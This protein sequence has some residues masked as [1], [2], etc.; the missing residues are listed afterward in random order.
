[1]SSINSLFTTVLFTPLEQFDDVRWVAS[2]VVERAEPYALFLLEPEFT[3]SSVSDRYANPLSTATTVATSR[4]SPRAGGSLLLVA[5]LAI[6][7]APRFI[8]ANTVVAA[9][10]GF[11]FLFF[12]ATLHILTG[13]IATVW[14][15]D[16]FYVVSGVAETSGE[17]TTTFRFAPQFDLSL[18]ID[19]TRVSL[20]L[21]FFLLGSGEEEDDEDFLLTESADL[22]L[23]EEIIAPLILSN[24]GVRIQENGAL[25]LKVC[26]LFGFVLANNLRGRLP[27]SDTATSSLG[28]T[29]WTALAVFASL[30]TLRIQS[31]GISYFFSLFRPA[32]CPFPLLFLLIPIEFISYSFR[33]VSLAV[34]LFA[35]RRA[36]HTLRKVLIGFSY[37]FLTLGDIYAV[38]ALL[39][40]LVVF[41]LVFLER[42][43]AVIQAYIFAVL[44]CL[45]L[46]DIYVGHLPN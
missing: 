12:L 5:L 15:S 9:F 4:L 14:F 29:F 21:G 46:K 35:N 11:S 24:L 42:G 37:V 7:V 32:G 6:F 34:R 16:L 3:P 17:I 19:E 25:Y 38:A 18:S 20:L 31:K 41:I 23:V 22:D 1:M 36:G 33:L 30:L 2:R 26:A 27:Y 43:V 45:Y 10:G 13:A 8:P 28:L 44:T 39:P 40:G